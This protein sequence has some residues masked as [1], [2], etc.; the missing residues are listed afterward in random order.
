VPPLL[1]RQACLSAFQEA[2]GTSK[3]T[4][5]RSSPV[6][7]QRK[8]SCTRRQA[9]LHRNAD[10]KKTWFHPL[11]D[12]RKDREGSSQA[13][14]NG[15][16]RAPYKYNKDTAIVI[17]NEVKDLVSTLSGLPTQQ[18]YFLRQAQGQQ[19]TIGTSRRHFASQRRRWSLK[20]RDFQR[21]GD[22]GPCLL[23]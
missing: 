12:S 23:S 9:H 4:V 14:K 5:T 20:G 6:K 19:A 8:L 11:P 22:S 17:L 13:G 3:P 15:T 21:L 7:W 10:R 2:Q 18:S 1:A 16:N